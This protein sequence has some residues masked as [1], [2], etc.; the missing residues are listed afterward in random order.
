MTTLWSEFGQ[1][2]II[3]FSTTATVLSQNM[4]VPPQEPWGMRYDPYSPPITPVTI[5]GSEQASEPRVLLFPLSSAPRTTTLKAAFES[6]RQEAAGSTTSG[7]NPKDIRRRAT[8]PLG[9][10]PSSTVSLEG[11][12]SS[13][14]Q[15]LKRRLEHLK[16]RRAK[17]REHTLEIQRELEEMER[18]MMAVDQTNEPVTHEGPR[19]SDAV[20]DTMDIT[21]SP[22]SSF[23]HPSTPTRSLLNPRRLLCSTYKVRDVTPSPTQQEQD[24]AVRSVRESSRQSRRFT[25]QE[26]GISGAIE[27][28]GRQH[29]E[30]PPD[31]IFC[32]SRA[33]DN[34]ETSPTRGFLPKWRQSPAFDPYHSRPSMDLLNTPVC[35][36]SVGVMGDDDM[37]SCLREAVVAPSKTCLPKRPHAW[38]QRPDK[39]ATDASDRSHVMQM[40]FYPKESSFDGQRQLCEDFHY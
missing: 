15:D 16:I 10:L 9:N 32:S 38:Y 36:R 37:S 4:V 14:I 20:D 6:S 30:A 31:A 39:I 17:Q 35:G 26:G 23:S 12:T 8:E 29:S 40:V 22:E 18:T 25:E 24:G 13:D 1:G 11:S 28:D 21:T 19:A 3:L 27:D 34:N 5:E 2:I 7:L 33:A